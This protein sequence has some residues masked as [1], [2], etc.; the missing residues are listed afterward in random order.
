[1]SEPSS[2]YMRV[3]LSEDGL[4]AF[5]TSPLAPPR[6]YNDWH[7]WLKSRKFT[8]KI[9]AGDIRTMEPPT[10][11]D[12]AAT[13]NRVATASG[14][15]GTAVASSKAPTVDDYLASM[16]ANPQMGPS[17]VHYDSISNLWTLAI[18]QCSENMREYI[19]IL[20][21]LRAVAKF[22]DMPGDDFILI[23]PYLW[24]GTPNAY[25]AIEQWYSH[26]LTVAA[27]FAITEANLAVGTLLTAAKR[28]GKA[29]TEL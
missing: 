21:I 7:D 15:A 10:A 4:S 25:V 14:Q 12:L 3:K 18:A 26:V 11:A 27:D 20:S 16:L 29:D 1:M 17:R 5:K 22:K 9:T 8:G 2:L 13:A 24:G 23:F 6:A 19:E 28:A